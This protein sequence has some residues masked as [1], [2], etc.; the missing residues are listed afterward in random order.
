MLR[1]CWPT[2][3]YAT[4]A[5]LALPLLSLLLPAG[6][7]TTAGYNVSLF[8]PLVSPPLVSLRWFRG[9]YS[10]YL[11]GYPPFPFASTQPRTSRKTILLLPLLLLLLP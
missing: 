8:F 2:A 7:P 1:P 4:L 6:Y 10:A 11:A 5:E 3:G 9:S